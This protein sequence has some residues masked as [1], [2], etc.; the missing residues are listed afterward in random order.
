MSKTGDVGNK[1][2][3]N[4]SVR[5]N[6]MRGYAADEYGLRSGS[7]TRRF[8]RDENNEQNRIY[9]KQKINNNVIGMHGNSRIETSDRVANKIAAIPGIDS[10]YVMMTDHNAYVAVKEKDKANSGQAAITDG[11]KDKIAQQVRALSPSVENVYVSANPDFTGR[12]EGY[13][14]DVRAGHPIQGFLN[15]FNALVERIFPAPSG[16]RTR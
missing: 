11:M 14:R 1:N 10:A 4:N 7:T 16:T 2:I 12:M 6:A 9:G 15:E 5:E 13:M 3:R 8:A